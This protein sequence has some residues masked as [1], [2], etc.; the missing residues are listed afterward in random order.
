VEYETY[1]AGYKKR[2]AEI[3]GERERHRQVVLERV[4]GLS[5]LFERLPGLERVYAF[6]SAAR[7]GSFTP[8]SDVDLAFE[9]LPPELLCETLSTLV[10]RLD[11]SVDALRIEDARGPLRE[12]I[13]KGV[14]VYERRPGT[15]P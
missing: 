12:Q 10:E 1:I 11:A 13:L 15:D 2:L 8:E 3:H 4:R 14:V 7:P 5:A 9:G 6:G